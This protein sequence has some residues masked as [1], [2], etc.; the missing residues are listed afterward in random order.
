MVFQD[1]QSFANVKGRWRVPVVFDNLIARGDMPPT[2]AVFISPGQD[3]SQ[4]KQN[5][6]YSNRSLEYDGL[7]DRFARMII[8]EII[9]EVEKQYTLSKDPEMRAIG[10][11]SS[12][13]ICA[14]TVAWERP[15]QFR[16]VFISVGSFTNLRGGDVY[17]ALVR[18]NRTQA[19]ACLHG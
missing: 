18:K 14:F 16:K 17:Q 19:A 3:K 11:S 6:R 13:G 15:N 12:G 8:E 10:G 9:P 7:G 2:I 1:G 5:G 4:T